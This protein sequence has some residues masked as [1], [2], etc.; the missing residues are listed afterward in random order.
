MQ[1]LILVPVGG[2]L[3]LAPEPQDSSVLWS[4]R[5][6]STCCL[7]VCEV[8]RVDGKDQ[9][10]TVRLT[11]LA[12]DQLGDDDLRAGVAQLRVGPEPATP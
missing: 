2:E 1:T 12:I 7:V 6:P 8:R 4:S 9:R 5:Q 3:S 10:R 11:E